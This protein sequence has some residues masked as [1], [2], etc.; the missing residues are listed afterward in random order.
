MYWIDLDNFAD[1]NL[2]YL[3]VPKSVERDT[4]ENREKN[5]CV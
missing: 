5:G 4:K 3:V 1:D 2:D